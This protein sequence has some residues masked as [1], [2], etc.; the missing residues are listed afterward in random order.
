M[1]HDAEGNILAVFWSDGG[2]SV[3]LRQP[4][5]LTRGVGT[6]G[7]G[8]NAV[9]AGV[10]SFAYLMRIEPVNYQV[11]RWTMWAS[12][13]GNKGNGASVKRVEVSDDGT[14]CFA[15]STSWG[16][17]Q[18]T[19]RLGDTEP[20][21]PYIAVLSPD[22]T[23]VRFASTISGA[24]MAELSDD[25]KWG[26][27][28]GTVNGKRRAVFLAGAG[29]DGVNYELV[30]PTPTLRPLQSRFGGGISD[31]WFAVVDLSATTPA[32]V[33]F[34]AKVSD[35]DYRREA[36][37]V[38]GKKKK[39]KWSFEAQ[40][41]MVFVF[42]PSF[43]RW[44]TT[45]AEFRHRDPVK[46]WP[47]FFY[48]KPVSGKLRWSKNQVSGSFTVQ[49]DRLAHNKGLQDRRVLG[50][51]ISKHP[52][53]KPVLRFS[54]DSIGATRREGFTKTNPKNGRAQEYEVFVA[55]ARGKLTVGNVT[56]P[57]SPNLTIK[58]LRS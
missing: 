5:D 22:M 8:L 10:T 6:R 28:T 32:A 17:T 52:E 20:G 18:T 14:T 16:M 53:Q 13:Y 56:V 51:L 39:S 34:E 29:K 42:D 54:I 55:P 41:G 11:I 40:D 33:P 37:R 19:N 36:S 58:H 47:N 27:F 50:D 3:A 1:T 49:C 26:I 23:G 21:G 2:N 31:G 25:S 57:V 45:D 48:G 9:G 46:V 44:V 43:P 4:T 35:L 12:R 38:G 15:G 24:G 30:T 7:T